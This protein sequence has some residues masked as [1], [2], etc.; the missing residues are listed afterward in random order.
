MPGKVGRPNSTVEEL[1]AVDVDD[2]GVAAAAADEAAVLV[3]ERV[4]W[5]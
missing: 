1:D 4:D 5:D 2:A 3:A